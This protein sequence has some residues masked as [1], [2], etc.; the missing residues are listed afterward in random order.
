MLAHRSG[1]VCAALAAALAIGAARPAAG[2]ERLR[3][4]GDTLHGNIADLTAD[5]VIFEPGYGKGKLAVKWADVETVESDGSFTVLH[6]E[7]GEAHGRILGLEGGKWL[8]I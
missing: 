4:K 1:A 8:L 6:G 2:E 7:E 5:G 3:S